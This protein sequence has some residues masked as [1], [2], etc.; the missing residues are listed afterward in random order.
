[1]ERME[2]RYSIGAG[3]IHAAYWKGWANGLRYC[4]DLI[5]ERWHN[6]I[7]AMADSNE[8][9]WAAFLE[10]LKEILSCDREG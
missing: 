1:M 5:D 9:V 3:H 7:D 8:R 6:F 4:K 10:D 2:R